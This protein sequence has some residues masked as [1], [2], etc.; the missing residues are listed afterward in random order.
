MAEDNRLNRDQA[1][2]EKK[3]AK[4]S[5]EAPEV[6]PMPDP[7]PG[8]AFRWVRIATL[9]ETDARNM[10]SKIREGWEPVKASDH[11]EITLVTVENEKFKD[12]IVIGGLLLCKMPQEMQD[13]RREYYE[14]ITK[15]QMDA[16]DNNLM[17]ENDARMPIFNDRKSN[18]TFGK[19]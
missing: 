7:Q 15:A 3:V 18:V 19:G 12:N 13:E 1:T 2:R 5:W 4:R 8:W 14:G 11:P 6:L 10:S 16:V 17:R 9:G